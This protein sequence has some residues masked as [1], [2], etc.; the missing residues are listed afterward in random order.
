MQ[1]IKI[2]GLGEQFLNKS[3][4]KGGWKTVLSIFDYRGPQVEPPFNRDMLK[5]AVT[6]LATK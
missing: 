4:C 5:K 1:V 3:Q 6:L 2:S